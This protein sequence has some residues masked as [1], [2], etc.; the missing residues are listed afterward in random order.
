MRSLP[1]GAQGTL[2]GLGLLSDLR[3]G[4]EQVTLVAAPGCPAWFIVVGAAL[5]IIHE[6]KVRPQ[7]RR[8][9]WGF[10]VTARWAWPPL[11]AEGEPS[12]ESCPGRCGR[13][14]GPHAPSRRGTPLWHPPPRPSNN[15]RGQCTVQL[16]SVQSLSR[17]RLSA[18]P[19]T[20]ARQA[21]LS[22]TNSRSLPKPMSIESV[23]P[24][25]HFIL[26]HPLLLLP[27]IFPS[28]RVFSNESA[29]RIRWPVL[30]FQLQHQSF[31]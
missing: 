4:R 5:L 18:T 6:H 22:I 23:I 29:L 27:S 26:C 3:A 30:E 17:V 12:V 16:S 20:A 25:N 19:W 7:G 21:S 8:A 24:S 10:S 13:V 14:D 11:R 15:L 2:L 31:Q 1:A 28:I 9:A